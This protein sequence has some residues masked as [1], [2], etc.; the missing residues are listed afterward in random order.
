MADKYYC[1][2]AAKT[3]RS[4]CLYCKKGIGEGELRIGESN[5][6][7]GTLIRWLHLYCVS[8]YL[9]AVPETSIISG[10]EDLSVKDKKT[11][12]KELSTTTKKITTKPKRKPVPVK[13]K[14][15]VEESS[16]EESNSDD[17]EAES[18]SSSEEKSKKR[19]KP[20]AKSPVASKKFK[21]DAATLKKLEQHKEDLAEKKKKLMS[22]KKC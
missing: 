4:K 7:K 3:G 15:K 20:T 16:S 22:L 17:S 8:Q 21:Y 12:E 14:K 18:E 1:V 19:K 2:E 13:K 9:D 5:D 10:F 11:V 6:E